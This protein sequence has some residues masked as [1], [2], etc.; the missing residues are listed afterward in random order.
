MFGYYYLKLYE[1]RVEADQTGKVSEKTHRLFSNLGYGIQ[2]GRV[3]FPHT[4]NFARLVFLCAMFDSFD[5]E[6]IP[7]GKRLLAHDPSDYQVK[8]TLTGLLAGSKSQPDI[9]LAMGY[10][11]EL[12]NEYQHPGVQYLLGYLYEK[13]WRQTHSKADANDAT[14]EY[15]QYLNSAP[16]GADYYRRNA[17]NSITEMNNS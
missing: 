5:R 16:P 4:Y 13:R 14:G 6:L 12:T 7:L 8:Y 11:H 15:R 3:K 10:A 9:D 2:F 17:E 1:A